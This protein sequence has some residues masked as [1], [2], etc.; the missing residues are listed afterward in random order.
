MTLFKNN[1]Q[2]KQTQIST[3]E[4]HRIW[5]KAQSRY[6]II[7]NINFFMNF[8]HDIDFK[9]VLTDFKSSYIKQANI[10]EQELDRYSLKSPEPSKSA[11]E[12]QTNQE[13]IS[14]QEIA[15]TIYG[16]VQLAV[17]KCVKIIYNATYNDDIREILIKITKEEVNK[18]DDFVDYLQLKGWIENPPLYPCN[19]N[20][21]IISANEIWELWEH[22]HYRYLN[23]Q[24]TKIY[25]SYASDEEFKLI[26][27]R[28]INILESQAVQIEKILTNYGVNLPDKHPKNIPTPKSKENYDDKFMYSAL[29]SSMRNAATIHGFAIQEFVINKDIRKFFKIIYFE[30]LDLIDK[31]IRYG[32][33]KGWVPMVPVFRA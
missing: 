1:K 26:L 14:D 31:I 20:I 7:N 8:V 6:V 23:I 32:K 22:L 19:K 29:L 27:G 13:V 28:G 5:V 18:V 2:K 12:A 9:K 17:G 30:E 11:I 3:E 15:R 16:L 33:L 25:K 10:L 24:Q 4:A 21:G